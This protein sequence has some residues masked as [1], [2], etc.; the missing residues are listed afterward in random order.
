[1]LGIQLWVNLPRKDKMVPPKYR[2]IREEMIPKVQA[3]L[4]QVLEFEQIDYN[5]QTV[6]E[7]AESLYPD[8]RKMYGMLQQY[9]MQK[10]IIDSNI[11]GMETPSRALSNA[12]E[13]TSQLKRKTNSL[14][15][16]RI[17]DSFLREAASVSFFFSAAST[18]F[19]RFSAAG[20][21]S[22]AAVS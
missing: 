13:A 11:F 3:R 7:L 8:I 5:D 1:M 6:N 22:T 18:F 17:R 12:R 19:N 21:T 9:S 20:P 16:S 10:G 2:D 4:K 15:V 14:F